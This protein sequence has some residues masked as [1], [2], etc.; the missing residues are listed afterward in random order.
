MSR[1]HQVTKD[2]TRVN[3]GIQVASQMLHV[4]RHSTVTSLKDLFHLNL[5]HGVEYKMSKIQTVDSSRK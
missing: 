1:T 3:T 5:A 4:K 2:L